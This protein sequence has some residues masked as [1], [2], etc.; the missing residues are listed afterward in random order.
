MLTG[1]STYLVLL[2]TSCIVGALIGAVGVG[3]VLLVPALIYLTDLG[4][5]QSM[6]TALCSFL[7]TGVAGALA[8]QRKGSIDWWVTLPLCLGALVCS[9]LGAMANA[10]VN[11]Q[12]LTLVLA[13]LIVVAGL[14]MVGAVSGMPSPA[15]AGRPRSQ[16]MLL[17]GLGS[18][19][20]FSSGLTGTGGPLVAVPLMIL[21]GF[22]PLM[23]VGA[24]QVLQ[25]IAAGSGTL[26]N[27]VY[28]SIDFVLV[29]MI[30]AFEVGGVLLGVKIVHAVDVLQVRRLIAWLCII[31]GTGIIYGAATG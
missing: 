17:V 23:T 8:F 29:A 1:I 20:G 2:L 27:L 18:V 26:G 30:V 16:W 6:A 7:A 28:G 9:Y 25:I 3:G 11:G 19:A 4:V 15:F 22:P 13:A 14:Y 12:V 31:I 10:Y 5:H 21:C 24:S